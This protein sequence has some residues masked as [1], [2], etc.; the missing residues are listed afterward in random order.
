M[1]TPLA[2]VL[3]AL[4]ALLGQAKENPQYGWWSSCKAGSKV[5]LR[6]EGEQGG[7]KLVIES[8]HTLLE[9]TAEKAVVEQ[10]TKITV[11]GTAQPEQTEKE[12]I[13]E[14]K[15]KDPIKIEKEGDEEIEVAGKKLKCHWIQGADK[16][17]KLKLWI[18]NEIPGSVAKGEI[19]VTAEGATM[20]INAVSW[21]KK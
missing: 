2:I 14:D 7:V 12:E 11:S 6:M 1:S 15:E 3:P 4:L 13:L 19:T 8:T 17:T 5:T 18:C 21:E 20:K 16:E 10:K 9:I